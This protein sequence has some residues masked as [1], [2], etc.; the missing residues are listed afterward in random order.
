[1]TLTHHRQLAPHAANMLELTQRHIAARVSFDVD[2]LG[3]Y[4]SKEQRRG[5]TQKIMDEENREERL[6]G[7]DDEH[8]RYGFGED[9]DS[10]KEA[11]IYRDRAKEERHK[12]LGYEPSTSK[13]VSLSP[14]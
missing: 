9:R 1:M 2:Y 3:R 12:R 10:Q 8:K 7:R 13:R 6:H 14:F 4:D 11:R 5:H